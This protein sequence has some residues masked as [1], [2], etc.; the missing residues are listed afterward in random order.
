VVEATLL[1]ARVSL[2]TT[3]TGAGDAREVSGNAGAG[4]GFT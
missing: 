1:G 3:V 2:G 4:L